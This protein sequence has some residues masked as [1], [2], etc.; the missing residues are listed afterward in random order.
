VLLLLPL[1]LFAARSAQAQD[2]TGQLSLTVVVV[3]DLSP[4][5]VPLTDFKITDASGTG[6][7]QVV[8]TDE[9][10]TTSVKLPPGKYAV[11]TVHPVSFKGH[12]LIW[13]ASCVIEA[14][15]ICQ[16]KLTDA[17]ATQT[18]ESPARQISDEARVYKDLKAGVVTVECDYNAPGKLDRGISYKA[19]SEQ[20]RNARSWRHSETTTAPS[21]KPR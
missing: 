17:D 21:S 2:T 18:V 19:V 12:G 6:A 20:R 5:P 11:E 15:Q 13:K 3:D 7:G 1:L 16:L 14:G 9:Q 10:G 8:R 4:R